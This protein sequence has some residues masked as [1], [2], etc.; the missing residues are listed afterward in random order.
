MSYKYTYLPVSCRLPRNMAKNRP[1]AP[2]PP[3]NTRVKLK[4][5]FEEV[6]SDYINASFVGSPS[7]PKSYIVTQY[8]LETT[9]GD[10]WRWAEHHINI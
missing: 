8:P 5:V 6:G 10:F 7:Y 3:S 4:L 9:V 1:Q 2:L